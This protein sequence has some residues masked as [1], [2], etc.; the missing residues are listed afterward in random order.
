[1]NAPR[2]RYTG[3][4]KEQGKASMKY[5]REK[6]D[7]VTLRFPKGFKPIVASHLELT[8]ESLVGFFKRAAEEAIARD[9]ARMREGFK[10]EPRNEE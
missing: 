9:R 5:I 2:T 7:T 6:T 4:T 1:M 8:G 3:Y 10:P